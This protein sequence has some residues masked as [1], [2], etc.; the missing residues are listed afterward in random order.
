MPVIFSVVVKGFPFFIGD[1]REFGLG[2]CCE[3]CEDI[4][5]FGVLFSTVS[6]F[7]K[8]LFSPIES[9]ICLVAVM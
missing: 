6:F 1:V 4:F 9:Q 2:V 8:M 5:D 3:F 7:P